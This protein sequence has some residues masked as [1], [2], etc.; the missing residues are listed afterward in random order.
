MSGTTWTNEERYANA[1]SV[2]YDESSV[3]YDAVN[4]NYNGQ[5]ITVWTNETVS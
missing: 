5:E 2:T 4:Y 3:T 1:P